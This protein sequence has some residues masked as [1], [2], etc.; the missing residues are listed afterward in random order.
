MFFPG[1]NITCFTF[2]YPFVTHLL[3]LP[4]SSLKRSSYSVYVCGSSVSTFDPVGPF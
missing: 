2:F 4:V 3:A 1:S